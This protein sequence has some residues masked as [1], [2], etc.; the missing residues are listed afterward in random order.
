MKVRC[1]GFRSGRQETILTGTGEIAMKE[2]SHEH[3][4]PRPDGF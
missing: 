4:H 2:T 1:L 3:I